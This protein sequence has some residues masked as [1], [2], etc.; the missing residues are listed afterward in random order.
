LVLVVL[1]VLVVLASLRKVV[2]EVW[3]EFLVSELCILWVVSEVVVERIVVVLF[4]V[5]A[6]VSQGQHLTAQATHLAAAS[7]VVLLVL[8]VMVIMVFVVV[9]VAQAVE[10]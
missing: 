2:A 10:V 3:V 6:T 7:R 4:L 1:V 5:V 9:A 8:V